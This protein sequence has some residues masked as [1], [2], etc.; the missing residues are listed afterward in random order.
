MKKR[1]CETQKA[2]LRIQLQQRA[3]D[4]RVTFVQLSIR[5]DSGVQLYSLTCLFHLGNTDLAV[6]LDCASAIA[7]P[8]CM[9]AMDVLTQYVYV[10]AVDEGN[11]ASHNPSKDT[12][13][14]FRGCEAHSGQVL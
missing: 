11:D 3:I 2:R 14:Y 6:F 13:T 8:A 9:N 1:S 4:S 5:I 10:G 12:R 7:M